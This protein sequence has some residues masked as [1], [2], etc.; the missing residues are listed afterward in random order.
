MQQKVFETLGEIFFDIQNETYISL[1]HFFEFHDFGS[2]KLVFYVH[3][4]I[5]IYFVIFSIVVLNI[6]R[7]KMQ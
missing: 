6:P 1:Q 2:Q 7:N 3:N 5:N 4:L